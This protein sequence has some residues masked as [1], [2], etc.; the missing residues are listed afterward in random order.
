MI[1]VHKLLILKLV[2]GSLLG[3]AGVVVSLGPV[4]GIELL[5]PGHPEIIFFTAFWLIDGASSFLARP[6]HA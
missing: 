5:N 3:G 6:P 2:L 4:P 1:L